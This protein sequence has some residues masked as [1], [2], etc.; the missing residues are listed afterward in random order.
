M[1]LRIG[2]KNAGFAHETKVLIEKGPLTE[3]PE[4]LRFENWLQFAKDA[5][6]R[7]SH[8]PQLDQLQLTDN[9]HLNAVHEGL[10]NQPDVIVNVL[11]QFVFPKTMVHQHRKLQSSGVDIG[12]NAIWYATWI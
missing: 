3:R 2:N 6:E 7:D 10:Y 1:G 4:Y 8:A 12:G 5:V 9:D 11:Q